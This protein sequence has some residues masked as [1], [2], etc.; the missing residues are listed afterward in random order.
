MQ[1]AADASASRG[2]GAYICGEET[3][4]IESIE[5]KRGEPRP[6]AAIPGEGRP[7]GRPTLVQNVETT[8]WLR[9]L[10]GDRGTD[11]SRRSAARTTRDALVLGQR[12][13][14]EARRV[15]AAPTA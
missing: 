12:T 5:G 14:E 10:L 9:A 7:F 2:A 15:P 4:L 6:A 13:G 8:Y 11:R 3:A 1:A